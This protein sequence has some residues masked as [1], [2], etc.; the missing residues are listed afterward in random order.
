MR[1]EL[2]HLGATEVR[3]GDL[4]FGSVKAVG[5][6]GDD[7]VATADFRRVADVAAG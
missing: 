4:R 1:A 7:L 2:A 6:D 5:R 3:N